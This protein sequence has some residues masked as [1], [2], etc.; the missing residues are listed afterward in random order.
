VA[1]EMRSCQTRAK[2]NAHGRRAIV[3]S[4][5]SMAVN[6]FGANPATSPPQFSP[7]RE[8]ILRIESIA[9]PPVLL[10]GD[11]ENER[12]T[13]EVF[14][15]LTLVLAL[16]GYVLH[17][18]GRTAL[19][20]GPRPPSLGDLSADA[21]ADLLPDGGTHYLLCW[22]DNVQ[23]GR[24]GDANSATSIHLSAALIDRNAKRILWRNAASQGRIA[25]PASTPLLTWLAFQH[26]TQPYVPDA[27]RQSEFD[28]ALRESTELGQSLLDLVSPTVVAVRN[29][30]GSFPER[31]M[32]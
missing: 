21:L 13:R 32:R 30:L 17:R 2:A 23:A 28:R 26:A 31:P 16:K 22:M 11:L 8:A 19:R 9:L 10:P 6:A 15:E 12:L 27:L 24:G 7:D 18:V 20:S 4:M 29:L 3:V 14:E 25:F 5:L 1:V